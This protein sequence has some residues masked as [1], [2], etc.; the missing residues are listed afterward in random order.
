MGLPHPFPAPSLRGVHA[1]MGIPGMFHYFIIKGRDLKIDFLLF[2]SWYYYT[3]ETEGRVKVFLR[4]TS[5]LRHARDSSPAVTPVIKFRAAVFPDDSQPPIGG[6][7]ENIKIL[8]CY[9][10]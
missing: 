10:Q 2:Q 4:H 1:L 8:Y 3:P 6:K 5:W 9:L 7:E